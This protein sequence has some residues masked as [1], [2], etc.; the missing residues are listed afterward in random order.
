MAA[1]LVKK[2]E[3]IYIVVIQNMFGDILSDL[4]SEIVGGLGLSSAIN[5]NQTQA[6]AQTVH[7]S[8]PDIVGKGI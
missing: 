5:A 2:I 7:G 6:M 8:A 1:H 4:T 3:D